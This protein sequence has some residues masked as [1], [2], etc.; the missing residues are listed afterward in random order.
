MEARDLQEFLVISAITEIQSST[1]KKAYRRAGVDQIDLSRSN[2]WCSREIYFAVIEIRVG[3]AQEEL[4]S[5]LSN[6]V[7]RGLEV[8]ENVEMD[9]HGGML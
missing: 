2:S 1:T 9:K 6:H 3:T 8:T 5:A 4:H 7:G